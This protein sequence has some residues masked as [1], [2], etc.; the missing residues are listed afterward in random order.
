MTNSGPLH[1]I[2]VLLSGSLAFGCAQGGGLP[3]AAPPPTDT[4]T[5]VDAGPTTDAGPMT[6]LDAGPMT[7][8]D[9]GPM[10]PDAGLDAGP[11]RPDAGFDAGPPVECTSASECDDGIGCNGAERC[12]GGTCSAGTP[13]GCDDGISC[14]VDSCVEGATPTCNF[15]PNDAL[16]SP[17]QTCT[18]TGC[19]AMCADSPCRLVGPQCGCPSGQ[20]CYVSG[21][22]RL[23]ASAGT[24]APGTT[25]SGV[26]GCTPGHICI[27][28]ASS[29]AATNMCNRFCDTDSDCAGGLCFYTLNDGAGGSVPDVTICTTPCDPIA[30]TGCPSTTSCQL[31]Q[32]SMGAMRYFTD[33]SAPTGTGGQGASCTTRSDC[34][35][36]FGC[37]GAPGQCLRWCD[38]IGFSGLLGGCPGSLTC[39]GFTTPIRVG[40]TTY[41]VCDV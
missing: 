27:N 25:C 5:P 40:S 1:F 28:V 39:Y 33:C 21:G 34:R 32:E 15:A 19:M 4:G 22:T 3:D 17:G 30:Q 16:C 10:R 23:C 37:V 36:G 31:L 38:G 7:G 26:S 14:T 12:I 18:G 20:G 2:S 29:G 11:M 6:G 41:G 24:S 8:L 9:A 13:F 35:A